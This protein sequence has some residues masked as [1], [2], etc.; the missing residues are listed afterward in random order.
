MCH[1]VSVRLSVNNFW[2]AGT[3]TNSSRLCSSPEAVLYA[4]W[5]NACIH[6]WDRIQGTKRGTN[7]IHHL[8]AV[9]LG[10]PGH[11][12]AVLEDASV[13]LWIF[14][15]L[16]GNDVL[17]WY[18]QLFDNGLNKMFK[19]YALLKQRFGRTFIKKHVFLTLLSIINFSSFS[20]I[21]CLFCL[22]THYSKHFD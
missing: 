15:P 8:T 5:T 4:V 22:N 14:S 11:T 19:M 12:W 6:Q 16:C 18:Y 7:F 9:P 21:N 20:F 13:T 10:F 2:S 3:Q 17:D 1:I